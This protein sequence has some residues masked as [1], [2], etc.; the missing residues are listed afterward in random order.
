VG[1]AGYSHH[2]SGFAEDDERK[3]VRPVARYGEAAAPYLDEISVSWG[4]DALGRG[5]TGTAIRTGRVS[6]ARDSS[7]SRASSRGVLPP[8]GIT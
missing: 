8:P 5:P 3:T 4:D 2:G 6:L 7:R 1:V